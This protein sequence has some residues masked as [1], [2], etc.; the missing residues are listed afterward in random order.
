M[1]DKIISEIQQLLKQ[2]LNRHTEIGVVYIFGSVAQGR[3][4]VLS[5][6]DFGIIVDRNG[7]L[8]V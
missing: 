2:Y 5:D 1:S 4:N 3:S 7:M 6:V 8:P